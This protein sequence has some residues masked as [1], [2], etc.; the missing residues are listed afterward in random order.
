MDHYKYYF[1]LLGLFLSVNLLAFGIEESNLKLS[2]SINKNK[3]ENIIL[4]GNVKK[5][6]IGVIGLRLVHQKGYPLY[7]EEVYPDS[8][9]SRIGIRTKDLIFVI[10]G[11]R[12]DYLS[13]DYVHKLLTGEPGTKTQLFIARNQT[14]LFNVELIREDLANCSPEIQNRY[15]SETILIPINITHLIP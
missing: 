10:D 1:V 12:T 7:V 15:L 2:S 14:I 5:T 4:K 9:A 13:F 3:N 6:D 11:I 8:P